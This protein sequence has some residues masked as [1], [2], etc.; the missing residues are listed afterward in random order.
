LPGTL[1]EG[2]PTEDDA[3]EAIEVAKLVLKRLEDEIK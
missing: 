3:K 1:P 2:L